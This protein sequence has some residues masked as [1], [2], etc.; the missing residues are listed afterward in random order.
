[1]A[2]ELNNDVERNG[3]IELTVR[4]YDGETGEFMECND[5]TLHDVPESV[6]R[7]LD[8]GGKMDD[9]FPLLFDE[10]SYDFP[11]EEP[12]VDAE[13]ISWEV[14]WSTFS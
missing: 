12:G 5:Y 6:A 1:M 8:N 9:I 14:D 11:E 13:I 2:N 4:L 3:E 7:T 10:Y